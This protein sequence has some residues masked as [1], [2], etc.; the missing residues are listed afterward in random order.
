M[1]GTL[2]AL[3]VLTMVLAIVFLVRPTVT[4]SPREKILAFMA[5]FILPGLCVGGG[6][7]THMQ[8]SEQTRFCISCHAMTPYG[9]SLYVDD[10]QYIP[11]AHFQNHRIPVETACYACHADYTIYGPLK[12]KLQ[13]II[14]IYMQY[15]SSPPQMISIRGGYSNLQCLH[16]HGGARSFEADPIHQAIMDTLKSNQTSC[17]SSGC[18]DTV[19]NVAALS[20]VKFWRPVQ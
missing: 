7:A 9:E 13:G 10:R 5:L 18:H 8:R 17:I 15:V 16:C 19:H 11:A 6:M 20:Q 2:I 1:L 14:R 3:I 12:D 4:V